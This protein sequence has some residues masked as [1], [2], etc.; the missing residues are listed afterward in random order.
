M[1]AIAN[2][3]LLVFLADGALSALDE[4]LKLAGVTSLSALRIPVAVSALLGSLLVYALLALG[5]RL[6][7]RIF[8]PPVVFL[9]WAWLGALPLSAW[10]DL[11]DLGL[12]LSLCQVAVGL[13]SLALVRRATGGASRLLGASAV[14][15]PGFSPG[16]LLKFALASALLV[17]LVLSGLL[18]FWGAL[19]LRDTTSGFLEVAFDGVYS[20]ERTYVRDD[21]TIHLIGMVHLADREF[22]EDVAASIPATGTI[23]L[24]EGISDETGLVAHAP[25]LESLAS[26]IGLTA[27][28]EVSLGATRT[29]ER[30]DLDM[31]DLSEEALDLFRTLGLVLGSR[32]YPEAMAIYA[33]YVRSLE[34]DATRA[35]LAEIID[36]RN[37]HVLA[38]LAPALEDHQRAILPWGAFHMPGLEA[39]VLAQG[40]EPSADRSRRAIRFW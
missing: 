39:G 5:P 15:G 24:A 10:V 35:V 27:Q 13:G 12:A 33:R 17:P 11:E 26:A 37:R 28:G 40:F 22:Y 9:V 2:L 29:F 36:A 6:P 38:R 16:H 32:S 19:V 4:L 14:E 18:A 23:V 7:K 3:Y 34:P 20:R 25:R 1:L 21:K 8:L 31:A 30:A